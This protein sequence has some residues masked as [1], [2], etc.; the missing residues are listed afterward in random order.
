MRLYRHDLLALRDIAI[1]LAGVTTFAEDV[2]DV[3]GCV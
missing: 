1:V 2:I 3:S